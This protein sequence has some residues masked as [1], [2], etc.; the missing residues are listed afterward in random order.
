MTSKQI[1]PTIRKYLEY[2]AAEDRP[3]TFTEIVSVTPRVNLFRRL[4]PLGLIENVVPP[5]RD[6][7]PYTGPRPSRYVLTDA[8]R[9]ALARKGGGE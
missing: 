9:A 5:Y 1:P 2:M 7:E 8:G 6:G 4:E 3:L